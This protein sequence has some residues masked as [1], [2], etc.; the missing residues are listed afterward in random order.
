[1]KEAMC[2]E[3]DFSDRYEKYALEL[4]EI[5]LRVKDSSLNCPD[6]TR[7]GDQEV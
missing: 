4:I 2:Y 7:R 5:Y 3:E 6:G 1:M